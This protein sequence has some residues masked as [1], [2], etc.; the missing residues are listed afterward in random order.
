[1]ALCPNQDWTQLAPHQYST[2]QAESWHIVDSVQCWLAVKAFDKG[3][4]NRPFS[5]YI[6]NSNT[7]EIL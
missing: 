1:M 5:V 6:T 2:E 3:Y 4:L 7:L